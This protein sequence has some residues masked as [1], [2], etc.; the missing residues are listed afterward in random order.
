MK[1]LYFSGTS[2]IL[3]PYRNKSY[4]PKDLKDRSRLAVYS[5]LFNSLEVNSTFYKI[6]RKETVERWS[7]ETSD[8]FRF[9]F[10]LWKG[11]THQKDLIF[12]PSDVIK[13]LDIIDS[14]DKKKG[15]LLIQLPPST[16]FY[17]LNN[18]DKL[19]RCMA[20]DKRSLDWQVC[21][22]F[23]HQ[24]WYRMETMA[25]L[26]SYGMNLVLH[27]KDG[28]G[29]N[30]QYTGNDM[31]YIRFHGPKGDYKGSYEDAVLYEYSGYIKEWLAEGKEVYAYFNN[32]IG[33]AIA[34]LRTLEEYIKRL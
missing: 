29:I 14:V 21:I 19:L 26:N 27:D 28:S 18:L 30:R 7:Q 6:P 2:G 3:L 4:Y 22:E 32:T 25:L 11:I 33:A 23:R 1:V 12:E 9:T 10:K 15:C 31:I 16:K 24:S 13:F 20:T 8:S 17:S 5:L 34:N